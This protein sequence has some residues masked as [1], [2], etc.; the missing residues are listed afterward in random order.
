MSSPFIWP[1]HKMA[2]SRALAS[3]S[4]RAI[5]ISLARAL[6]LW[7]WPSPMIFDCSI[8]NLL[9]SKRSRAVSVPLRFP[10]P[11]LSV[12]TC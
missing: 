8:G 3:F 11:P 1:S 7:L 9:T 4:V 5:S 12:N 10:F 2:Y 6:G